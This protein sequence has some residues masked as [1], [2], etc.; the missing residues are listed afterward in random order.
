MGYGKGL[1]LASFSLLISS[2]LA[3]QLPIPTPPPGYPKGPFQRRSLVEPKK[4][5]LVVNLSAAAQ[6]KLARVLQKK[7]V[8]VSRSSLARLLAQR[9]GLRQSLDLNSDTFV[10]K[11]R[12]LNRSKI[13]RAVR[14]GLV[15][16]VENNYR[17]FAFGASNDL[18]YTLGLLW[19]INNTGGFFGGKADVDVDAPEAWDITTGDGETVVGIIDTGVLRSHPDLA[20]NIWINA[21]EKENGFDDDGNGFIDDLYG[22]DFINND[23]DPTDDHFHGTHVAGTVAAVQ[24][25][26]R[27]VVGVAPGVKVLAL[28]VLDSKGVGDTAMMVQAIDY[29]IRLRKAG[30]N[31]RVLNASLG[32]GDEL[33]AVRDVLRRASA[34]GIVFV[35]AAGNSGT[36][37]D[38]T[39]VYPAN[40][41]V[42]NL[43]AVA[44]LN[45]QGLLASFSN[46]GA[47]TV[48][49]AAPGENIWSTITH[50]FYLPFS[51]T[52]MAAPHVSGVAA[53]VASRHPQLAPAQ[54]RERIM[55]SVKP[56]PE[57]AGKVQAAGIVSAYG[58]VQ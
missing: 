39:P 53:L 23:N 51:G 17:L 7:G 28:K 32:G 56:L 45:N 54:I 41:N 46:Y 21:R 4:G 38:R 30:V 57:L 34:A 31:I 22:W 35:A 18:L 24:N 1:L 49:V 58:A 3:A 12:R 27:G 14:R 16:R 9:L 43:I 55:R 40:Y 15:S 47:D 33:E 5:E 10:V 11:G 26:G 2:P 19:G 44:A 29:A 42:A 25:N 50:N 13:K 36:D 37:N 6:Q 8:P 48:H 20:A 52:S